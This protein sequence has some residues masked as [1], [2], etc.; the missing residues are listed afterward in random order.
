MADDSD[1]ELGGEDDAGGA[2]ASSSKKKSKGLGGMLPTLLKFIA[3]GLGAIIIIVTVTII[4]VNVVGGEG[5]NQTVPKVDPASPYVGKQKNYL[6][7][8]GIGVIRTETQDN[9]PYSVVVNIVLGYDE[10]DTVTPT[11]LAARLPIL[12]DFVRNF[13]RKKFADDLKPE[14]EARL[15]AEIMEELNTRY[16]SDSKIRIILFDQLDV[17]STDF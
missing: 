12:K 1:L 2:P 13:F 17:T 3:F 11:V 7:Y 9:P 14:N 6:F 15:K 4:T 5:K 10:L 8:S 16:L